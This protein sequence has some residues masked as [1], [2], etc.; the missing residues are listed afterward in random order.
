LKKYQQAF[1]YLYQS[2][3]RAEISRRFGVVFEP[4]VNGQAEIAGLPE[5]PLADDARLEPSEIVRRRLRNAAPCLIQYGGETVTSQALPD[6]RWTRPEPTRSMTRTPRSGTSKA[7]LRDTR[8]GPRCSAPSSAST[9]L[10][11][12]QYAWGDGEHPA[13]SRSGLL[14]SGS[15]TFCAGDWIASNHMDTI[16]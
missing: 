13:G 4:V 11:S 12:A 3:L 15:A 2:V 8:L 5:P 9:G 6:L 1:G 14:Q 7:G 16:Q 10:R